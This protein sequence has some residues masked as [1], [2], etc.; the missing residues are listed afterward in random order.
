MAHGYPR[1]FVEFSR[2]KFRDHRAVAEDPQAA[3]AMLD[4][5][6]GLAPFE[7]FFNRE[8]VRRLSELGRR[9]HEAS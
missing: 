9:L 1:T 4:V 5:V 7:R 3:T 2:Q 6:C 8:N